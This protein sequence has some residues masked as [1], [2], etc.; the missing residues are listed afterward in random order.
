M[1]ARIE[2]REIQCPKL[3]KEVKQIRSIIKTRLASVD[4]QNNMNLGQ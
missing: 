3:M 1:G 4:Q 2:L